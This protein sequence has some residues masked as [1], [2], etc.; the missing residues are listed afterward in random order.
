ME[1]RRSEGTLTVLGKKNV[2]CMSLFCLYSMRLK[3]VDV[4]AENNV[5]IRSVP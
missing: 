5:V 1:S 4:I 2:L 3:N